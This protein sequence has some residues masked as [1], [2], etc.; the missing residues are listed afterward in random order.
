MPFLLTTPAL[1]AG[2]ALI[3]LPV[4]A[5]LL[6]RRARRRVVFPSVELLAA[7]RA[8]HAAPLKLRRW[9]LLALRALAVLAVVL[10]FTRPL[11]RGAATAQ[12]PGLAASDRAG[13]LV[14]VLDVSASTAQR[15]DDTTAFDRLR[16]QA[17]RE[18]AAAASAGDAAGLVLAGATARPVTDRL[19]HNVELLT[20]GLREAAP[21]DPRADLA[22]ALAAAGALFNA[23]GAPAENAGRQI[24]VLTDGQAS[25]WDGL[26]TV[27]LPAG[28]TLTVRTSDADTN[29]TAPALPNAGLVRPALRPAVPGV[30]RPAEI[31]AELR[32]PP[33]PQRRLRVELRIADSRST[34]AGSAPRP[35]ARSASPSP[36]ALTRPAPSA[37]S[38]GWWG[39]ARTTTR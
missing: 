27:G 19:T 9:L 32:S 25:N 30:G 22:G 11:W 24:V 23:P 21:A 33:G 5:H 38:C 28:V 37:S 1:L 4:V 29:A 18:L 10:A 35:P 8:S 36:T 34:P 7:A 16:D 14:V 39:P 17:Q 15:V 13:A 31:S 3:A 26:G 2:L 6:N 20:R 12:V